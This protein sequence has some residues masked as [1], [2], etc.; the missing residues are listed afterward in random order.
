MGGLCRLK[1]YALQQNFVGSDWCVQKFI[2][3][4]EIAYIEAYYYVVKCQNGKEIV[5]HEVSTV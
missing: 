1:D 3:H 5:S 2:T 4:L